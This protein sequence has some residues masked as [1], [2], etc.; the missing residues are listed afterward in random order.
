MDNLNPQCNPN[1]LMAE[2]RAHKN[3]QVIDTSGRPEISL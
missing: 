3:L 1:N 2:C